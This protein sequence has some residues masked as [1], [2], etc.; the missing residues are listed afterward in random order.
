MDLAR[1]KTPQ[2]SRSPTTPCPDVNAAQYS[3]S[4]PIDDL[5]SSDEQDSSNDRRLRATS[6]KGT[7]GLRVQAQAF[8]EDATEHQRQ[9]QV[10]ER[11]FPKRRKI[12]SDKFVFQPSTLDKLIIGI[13]EQVHGSI[14][15]DPEAIFEQFQVA[16][17][18]GMSL[19]GPST[20]FSPHQT[21]ASQANGILTQATNPA[22]L[23]LS[24]DFR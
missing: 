21:A 2:P 7:G 13:W 3:E 16:P 19:Q 10:E 15:L 14:N 8:Q 1:W 9:M 18:G 20:T 17:Q 12:A 4:A 22:A 6:R 23:P 11:T 5:A 24:A